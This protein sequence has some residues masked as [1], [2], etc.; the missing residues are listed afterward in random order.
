MTMVL[1]LREPHDSTLKKNLLGF[2]SASNGASAVY[3]NKK[4][5]G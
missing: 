3:G 4:I 5:C 1:G 2:P